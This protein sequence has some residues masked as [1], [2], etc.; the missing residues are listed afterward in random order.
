[1]AACAVEVEAVEH[2]LVEMVAR[3]FSETA[4][5]IVAQIFAGRDRKPQVHRRDRRYVLR[6]GAIM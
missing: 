2:L 1:M 6:T 3:L 5:V 4:S